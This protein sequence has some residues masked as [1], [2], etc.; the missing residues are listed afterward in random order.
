ML[1][2]LVKVVKKVIVAIF[3]LYGL[4]IL[5]SSMNIVIP[6]NVISIVLVS[7]LGLPG[8]TTLVIL[9]LII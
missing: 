2:I 1:N 7:L 9:F 4:N 3:M 6:I 8:L 5:I